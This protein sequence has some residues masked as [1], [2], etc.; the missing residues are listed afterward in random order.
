[1]KPS[2]SRQAHRQSFAVHCG[3]ST[4]ELLFLEVRDD[5]LVLRSVSGVIVSRWWYERIVN[6]TYSPRSKIFCLWRTANGGQLQLN[7]YYTKKVSNS[8]ISNQLNI[9]SEIVNLNVI[10]RVEYFYP[11]LILIG[12]IW[13]E[14][15]WVCL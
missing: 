14:G 5:G 10:S 8:Y 12:T 13:G 2:N 7:K 1:L 6:M 11:S 3:D 9:F 4:G 15:A